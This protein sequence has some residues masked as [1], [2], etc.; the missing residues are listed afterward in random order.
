M[1]ALGTDRSLTMFE[2]VY[3]EIMYGEVITLYIETLQSVAK[4]CQEIFTK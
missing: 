1:E 3:I 4:S 2:D